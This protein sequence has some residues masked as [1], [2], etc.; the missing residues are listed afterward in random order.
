MLKFLRHIINNNRL[1]GKYNLYQ[2]F[3]WYDATYGVN[4]YLNIHHGGGVSFEYELV[5]YKPRKKLK[6]VGVTDYLPYNIFICLF[7]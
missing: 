3:T 6:L 5:H 4:L 1:M 2:L 7:M